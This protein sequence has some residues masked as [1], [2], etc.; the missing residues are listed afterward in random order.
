MDAQKRVCSGRTVYRECMD[1]QER[2]CSGRTVYRECMDV[3]GGDIQDE[4]EKSTCYNLNYLKGLF[5]SP[6]VLGVTFSQAPCS[7]QSPNTIR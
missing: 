2:V 7:Y 4:L 3:K 6:M 1:A 5:N